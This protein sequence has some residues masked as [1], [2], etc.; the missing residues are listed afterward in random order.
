MDDLA[1]SLCHLTP[2]AINGGDQRSVH[3]ARVA[4][5]RLRAVIDLIS[6]VLPPKQTKAMSRTLRHL[7]RRLGPLRDIDVMLT[8]LKD[9]RGHHLA[10]AVLAMQ[11]LLHAQSRAL[12]AKITK[13]EPPTRVLR[14]LATWPS[15]QSN[16]RHVHHDLP[17]LLRHSAAEQLAAFV[18]QARSTL[19]AAKSPGHA[20]PPAWHM[21]RIA[22]KRLRYTLEMSSAAGH[23]LP[24]QTAK[25]FKQMQD[26]LGL[27][28]DYVVL[29]DQALQLSVQQHLAMTNPQLL[30]SVVA[31]LHETQRRASRQLQLFAR[32]WAQQGEALAAQIA[33]L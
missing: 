8:H 32:I 27:W 17:G 2:L 30:T 13:K 28:H 15:L 31:L 3:H 4:T 11:R 22:G 23:D 14:N 6:P 1:R 7:R 24:P 33:A 19:G 18:R 9:L 12:R 20:S 5:R 16:I 10:A 29:S 26:A 25:V 21:L